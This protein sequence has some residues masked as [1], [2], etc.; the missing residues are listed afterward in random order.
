[1]LKIYKSKQNIQPINPQSTVQYKCV[2]E[3]LHVGSKLQRTV[4]F[5]KA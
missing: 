4:Q 1:M 2:K 5:F 3:K